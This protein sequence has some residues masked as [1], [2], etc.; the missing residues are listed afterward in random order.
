MSGG[1]NQSSPLKRFTKTVTVIVTGVPIFVYKVLNY[2]SARCFI[3]QV[4]PQFS[5]VYLH[6]RI[7]REELEGGLFQ[8]FNLVSRS[9]SDKFPERNFKDKKGLNPFK[10]LFFVKI[11]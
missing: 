10:N 6:L 3:F 11:C 9:F 4:P 1:D 7:C 8:V 2:F 5:L